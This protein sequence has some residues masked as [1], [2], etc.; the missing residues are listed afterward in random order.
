MQRRLFLKQVGALTAAAP[1]SFLL[2]GCKQKTEQFK[3]GFLNPKTGVDAIS[4]ASCERAN[5]IALPFLN[6]LGLNAEIIYS[7]TESNTEIA[8][9]KAERLIQK[10]VHCLVGAFNSAASACVAEVARAAKIPHIINISAADKITQQENP[11]VF[12]NFPSSSIFASMGIEGILELFKEKHATF[13]TATLMV[14]NDSYGQSVMDGIKARQNTLPFKIEEIIQFDYKAKDLSTE[15]SR[16]KAINSEV[17]LLVSRVNTTNL[18]VRELINQQH[19]PKLILGISSQGFFESPFYK[20]YGKKSDNL[21]TVHAWFDPR[22]EMT[23][24][25]K[26]LFEEA[27]PDEIFELNVG[28]TLEAFYIAC[29]AYE[30]CKSFDPVNLTNA[31]RNMHEEKRMM[32]G[33]PICFDKNGQRNNFKHVTLMNK[34]LKPEIVTPVILRS[35]EPVLPFPGF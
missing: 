26:S 31:L 32:F 34:D 25:A 12:R 20:N 18:I 7:D 14:V 8:R 19:N 23:K 24:I 4:G 2:S 28:F 21:Y 10:G 5:K 1:F 29:K 11:Y 16:L 22:Q 35:T 9:I 6:H 33:G 13:K 27:F 30:N 17:L 15:I 3:I